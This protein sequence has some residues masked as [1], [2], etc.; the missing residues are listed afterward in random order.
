M[1]AYGHEV[2]AGGDY[3]VDLARET[4]AAASHAAASKYLVEVFPIHES[5]AFGPKA[6]F[7]TLS[8]SSMSQ[9]GSR[10]PTSSATPRSGAS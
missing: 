4:V 7:L 9:N 8:Q 1:I 5:F 10:L 3:Y 6:P 2:V